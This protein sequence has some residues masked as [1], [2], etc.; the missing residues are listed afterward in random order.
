MK[1][2]IWLLLCAAVILTACA[3]GAETEESPTGYGIYFREA[4]L[5]SAAGGDALRAEYI[6]IENSGEKSAQEMA[7][8]LLAALLAGPTDPTLVS[9]I[10]SG[11]TLLSVRVEDGRALVDLSMRYNVLSGVEL[12]LAD[13]AVTMTLSQLPEV[14]TTSITV[15][16]QKLAYRD[17]Q[18][19]TA[20]DVLQTTGEDVVST[21]Q[22]TLYFP[23]ETGVLHPDFQ[24]LELYEGDTQARM[25]AS[26]LRAGPEADDLLPVLPESWGELP[27]WVKETTCYVNLSSALL[28]EELTEAE[29]QLALE[30][31]GRSLCGLET[32]AEVRF[33]VDGAFSPVYGTVDIS[34]A[35]TE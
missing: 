24:T 25:V 2:V 13:Y 1:R 11:T 31:L 15:H 34:A 18:T 12:T 19:F 27:V 9:T 4:D 29:V 14:L 16:G 17:R 20:W 22:A 35:Y 3:V 28:T 6:E 33:L 7:E 23:D 5:K 8:L 26:A 30:A 10:P 21:L 32:V